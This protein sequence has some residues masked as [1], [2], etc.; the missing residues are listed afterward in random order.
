MQVWPHVH[1]SGYHPYNPYHGSS[2]LVSDIFMFGGSALLEEC[3][4]HGNSFK[5]GGANK[6]ESKNSNELTLKE[7][8]SLIKPRNETEIRRI[9][10][11]KQPRSNLKYVNNSI[12]RD[13]SVNVTKKLVLF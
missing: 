5:P 11:Y 6:E 8:F 1:G 10:Y 12:Y 3:F 7:N 9:H 2:P 13:D 4:H